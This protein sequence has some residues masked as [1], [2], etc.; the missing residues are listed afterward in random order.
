MRPSTDNNRTD[1]VV[2]PSTSDPSVSA[3]SPTKSS[4]VSP[5]TQTPEQGTET[6]PTK[7]S[8]TDGQEEHVS[9]LKGLDDGFDDL[10]SDV[11][12]T[13]SL[14][15]DGDR[16]WTGAIIGISS[17]G[18]A[19][20][21]LIFGVAYYRPMMSKDKSADHVT[22]ATFPSTEA[23]SSDPTTG[24]ASS[25]TVD[26]DYERAYRRSDYPSLSDA[27]A[28]FGSR[29]RPAAN[30]DDLATIPS[31]GNSTI[32]LSDDP[33]FNQ[34]FDD[35]P[36]ELLDIFAPEGKLGVVIDTPDDY[37][38]PVVHAIKDTSPIADKIQVGDKIVALDDEDVRAMTAIEV[39]KLISRKSNN[40]SRKLTVIRHVSSAMF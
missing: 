10:T 24:D 39:S 38:A 18:G 9:E 29:T 22:Q 32:C 12:P 23:G 15:D 33:T 34:A 3:V 19:L 4:T 8:P 11:P 31:S 20:I 14:S 26:Y 37:S 36:E 21:L 17:I 25:V 5:S 27:G 2:D 6:S 35:D 13:P 28:T 1:S 16:S 40:V 30:E 7:K